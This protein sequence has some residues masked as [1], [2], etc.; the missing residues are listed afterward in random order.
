MRLPAGC[1]PAAQPLPP[2]RLA[3]ITRTP[4]FTAATVERIEHTTD[5]IVHGA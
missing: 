4:T 1:Q 3:A 5:A 2:L